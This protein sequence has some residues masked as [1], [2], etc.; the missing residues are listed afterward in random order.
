MIRDALWKLGILRT[1]LLAALEE[2]RREI[3][4][5]APDTPYCCSGHECCCEGMTLRALYQSREDEE[6]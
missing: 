6:R 5:R 2:W 4:R 1:M 3:W